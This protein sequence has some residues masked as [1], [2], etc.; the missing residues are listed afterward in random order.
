MSQIADYTQTYFIFSGKIES[1][2]FVN[3]K[4]YYMYYQYTTLYSY[5]LLYYSPIAI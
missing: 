3:S 2:S 1:Y 4:N 5:S